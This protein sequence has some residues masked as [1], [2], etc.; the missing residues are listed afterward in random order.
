[1]SSDQSGRERPPRPG[2][3]D[4]PQTTASRTPVRQPA[5]PLHTTVTMAP[6]QGTGEETVFSFVLYLNIFC[7]IEGTAR[8]MGLPLSPFEGYGLWPFFSNI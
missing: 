5:T 4:F 2:I 7:I 3:S 1:M 6:E 8:Y